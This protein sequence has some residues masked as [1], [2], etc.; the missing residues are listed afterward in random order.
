ME[1]TLLENI[2]ITRPILFLCGP[3]Y[4]KNNKSDRRLILQEKIYEIHKNKFLP[5]VIDDFLTEKNIKDDTI[6]IQLMEEICAAVSAQTYIFLDT[7]SSAA[8]LGIFANSAFFNKIKVY[9]PKKSDIY[10]KSNVGYFVRD[11]VLM[12]HSD[13][14]ECLEYRP[15]VERNAI[16]TD[17]ILEY[18][19]FVNNQLPKNIEDDIR[20]DEIFNE[21]DEHFIEYLDSN[22]M[23]DNA[24]QICYQIRNNK[25]DV[26]ISI[27]ILFYITISVISI[28][29]KNDIK[30]KNFSV[31]DINKIIEQVK[32]IIIN[33]LSEK[34]NKDLNTI[35]EININTVSKHKIEKII[36]HIVKFA[37]IY[38]LYSQF[39]S[40]YLMEK[41]IGKILRKIEVGN[42][43]YTLLQ[44]SDSQ[45]D[46]L[47]D[48]NNNKDKYYEKI[49]IEKNKK[50]RKIIKYINN[51][52][53]DNAKKIHEYILKKIYSYYRFNDNSYAYQKGKSIKECVNKH[54]EGKSF[55]KYDIKNFFESIKE[56]NLYKCLVYI[57]GI[58]KRFIGA[59]KRIFNSC[60]YENTL[61]LGLTLSP[62]L[63][64]M[65]LKK[66]DDTISRQLEEKG[67]TYSRY[68][69]D[70]MISSKEII[71][72]KLYH[73]INKMVTDELVKVNLILNVKKSV[74]VTFNSK[75]NFIRYVGVNIVQGIN[76]NYLSVGKKY[77]YSIAK[78]YLKY[79]DK[80]NV[81]NSELSSESDEELEELKKNVFYR[82]MAIIGKVSFLK[83]IE[84]DK[85]CK[86]LKK[87]LEKYVDIDLEK[88]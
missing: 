4:N 71:D 41:P 38:Y 10:N 88:I 11:V 2:K 33:S 44:L 36:Q 15:A 66:F 7:M 47:Q 12:K 78:E 65:Y 6:D 69:D 51:N 50:K 81:L 18:Y 53:G 21:S 74:F 68:A 3:Y 29:Y 26:N 39:H 19:K 27:K 55:I 43:P 61:P 59:L 77:I 48:I 62:V 58:D 84:G 8:E 79:M 45:L 23:P 34:T 1:Y 70:I 54:I 85:G 5:L 87:R 76:G 49:V 46:L 20:N 83:Q 52:D 42:H 9:I 14:I 82:R 64:D 30:E 24:Y 16:A 67:I 31:F 13:K 60:F 72:E 73:E 40:V 17:Y 22:M 32:S 57:F 80:V 37:H 56:E 28:E 86:R 75:C 63:S 25:I 35:D